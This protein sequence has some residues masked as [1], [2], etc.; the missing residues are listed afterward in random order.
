[1]VPDFAL[2]EK[3]LLSLVSLDEELALAVRLKGCTYCGGRLDRADYPRK[4]RGVPASCEE[5]YGRR[6]SFCCAEEGCRRRTTPPSLR[7]LGR[8]VYVSVVVVLASAYAEAARVARRQRERW[9]RWWRTK[10]VAG[11]FWREARGRL[12]PPVTEERLPVSLLERFGP[13]D[14]EA[15]LMALLRFIAPVTTAPLRA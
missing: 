12:L 13:S 11:R 4:G 5:A 10:L 2:T 3:F 14:S 8:K 1:M 6:D 15:S 9:R 7:F